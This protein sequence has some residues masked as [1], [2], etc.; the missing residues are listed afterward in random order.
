VADLPETRVSD[1]ERDQVVASLREH[2]AEG[3]LTLDE[4]A[5][6]MG[7]ALEAR[8]KGELE[9]VLSDLPMP[10][11]PGSVVPNRRA[12]R[13][14]VAFM[15]GAD[16]KGR[17]RAADHTTAVAVMGGCDMD[18]RS[19]EIEGGEIRISAWALWGGI[20]IVVPEGIDVEVT[21]LSVMGGRSVKLKDVPLVPGSPRV[22]IRAFPVMGGV[23]VRSK[24]RRHLSSDAPPSFGRRT[25]QDRRSSDD[26][27]LSGDSR[28]SEDR[29]LSEGQ[30][31][32]ADPGTT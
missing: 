22:V 28:L 18:L 5:D 29:R 25:A 7:T 12:R 30:H 9:P 32:P 2:C 4:F 6:R 14:L 31:L 19:A 3:R 13:W 10:T 16:M 20:D 24:P 21:G 26:H 17:W 1:A 8:T 15:S 23:T 11:T 27:S